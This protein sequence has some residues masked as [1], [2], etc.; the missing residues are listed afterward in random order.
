M[1]NSG[2]S[3]TST[4]EALEKALKHPKNSHAIETAFKGFD[5]NHDGF[6]NKQEAANLLD[7][8]LEIIVTISQED[9]KIIPVQKETLLHGLT[10]EQFV[11]KAFEAI[12]A[13]KD[14]KISLKEFR[15]LIQNKDNLFVTT[16][17]EWK[18][19]HPTEYLLQ[20]LEITSKV[21]LHPTI[22]GW[23]MVDFHAFLQ[24]NGV[25]RQ[26]R[27]EVFKK[28]ILGARDVEGPENYI[29]ITCQASYFDTC[30]WS[31]EAKEFKW[32]HGYVFDFE[33]NGVKETYPLVKIDEEFANA[34][35]LKKIAI[36]D[37]GDMF[38]GEGVIV[39]GG[40]ELN[41]TYAQATMNLNF[42]GEKSE[43]A[44]EE[45]PLIEKWGGDWWAEDSK[46]LVK[47]SNGE[48]VAGWS[49]G[50]G[51][52][53]VSGAGVTVTYD[54]SF[55]VVE[56]NQEYELQFIKPNGEVIWTISFST[57][58]KWPEHFGV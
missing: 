8:L 15:N 14:G 43:M 10:M 40:L 17:L 35:G 9:V 44:W 46:V 39:K 34:N 47:K 18:E 5:E 12:D 25:R 51:M 7:R 49:S 36:F 13:N 20:H 31:V 50:F 1:G 16:F 3:N 27:A 41:T 55:E 19:E 38:K 54:L 26:V 11:N 29:H 32:G 23:V 52:T 56:L 45:A 2:S 58:K 6:V 42:I 28:S 24:E 22:E 30:G 4:S 53:S 21:S 33:R 37:V 48:R 57:P